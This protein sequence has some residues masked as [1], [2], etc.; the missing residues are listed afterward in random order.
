MKYKIVTPSEVYPVEVEFLKSQLRITHDQHDSY[1][2]SLIAAATDWAIG[3][4]G[5]QINFATLQ[6]YCEY[7]DNSQSK[8]HYYG[9][10]GSCYYGMN[11]RRSY[12]IERG[13]VSGITKIEY[14]N[15]SGELIE[16]TSD[17]YQVENE[18]Y[19]A[20]IYINANYVFNNIDAC[21]PDAIRITYTAGYG[22]TVEEK[23]TPFPELVRNAVA[24]K[25]A[26]M[27]TTP[28]DGVDEK[29]SVAE[30]LLKSMRCP[31]V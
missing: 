17:D 7:H 30:N 26:R 9:L 18:E 16:L 11:A 2:T 25:A 14:L 27:Y 3:Y 4:T 8:N 6:A 22:G 24:M 19:S 23:I 13:P 29:T 20:T 1:L 10:P 21:R 28:D 31:I 5:R 12:F 15:L